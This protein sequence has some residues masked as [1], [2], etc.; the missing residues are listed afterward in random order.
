V[1]LNRQRTAYQAFRLKFGEARRALGLE[2]LTP[3][4]LEQVDAEL[5]KITARA[6]RLGLNINRGY[7]SD[8]DLAIRFGYQEDLWV[9]QV[10]HEAVHGN[11]L[12]L[13]WRSSRR[14]D[15]LAI[16]TRSYDIDRMCAIGIFSIKAALRSH[17]LAAEMLPWAWDPGPARALLSNVLAWETELEEREKLKGP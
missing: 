2:G 9:Q 1:F 17:V 10:S 5:G 13:R 4:E 16:E 14:G 11:Q 15:A 3:E 7:P 6:R 8:R 12:M